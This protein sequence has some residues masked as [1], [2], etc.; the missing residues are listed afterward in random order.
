MQTRYGSIPAEVQLAWKSCLGGVGSAGLVP[1][2]NYNMDTP[3]TQYGSLPVAVQL[4]WRSCLGWFG[5]RGLVPMGNYNTYDITKMHATQT[6]YGSIP[7]EVW[8]VWRSCL[9]GFGLVGLVATENGYHTHLVWKHT[10]GSVACAEELPQGVRLSRWNSLR[11]VFPPGNGYCTDPLQLAWK[12]CVGGFGLAGLLPMGNYNTYDITKMHAAQTRY[13]SIPV[14]VWLVW[15]S[16]LGG[17]GL[18]GLVATVGE[19]HSEIYFPPKMDTTQTRYGSIPAEVRLV[20][21]SCLRG[22]GSA[23]LVSMGTYNVYLVS[24]TH[25]EMYFPRKM[26][27]AQIRCGLHGRAAS[28]GLAW[29][30]MHA[31]QTQYGSILVAV[32]LVWKCCLGWFGLAG[33]VAMGNHN[34]YLKMD[35]AQTW[36]GLHGRAASG[37]SAW[38]A[39]WL[40]TWYGSILAA[41][42]LV[43]KCC[44]GWFGSAGLVAMGNHNVYLTWCGLHGRAAS[45][46]SAWQAEWLQTWYGS[47]LA[48]VRLV[49]KR[50]LGWFSSA[51]LVAMGNHNVY[52]TWCSLHGRAASEGSAQ[53]ENGYRTDL[54]RLVQK[55]CLGWFSSAGLVPIGN[56]NMYDTTVSS[57]LLTKGL[58]ICCDAMY[59]MSP[60]PFHVTRSKPHGPFHVT[61]GKLHRPF[62]VTCG[63]L[64]GPFH[65]T[66]GKQH[67]P[68]HVTRGKPHRPFHVTCSKLYGPSHVIVACHKGPSM[69]LLMSCGHTWP[70]G[71]LMSLSLFDLAGLPQALHKPWHFGAQAGHEL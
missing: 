44:L 55:S 1:I 4:V 11:N 31:T 24:G 17:F 23:G 3:L 47:I 16:C 66:C 14:E 68:F 34:V 71:L 45:G 52:L 27:T 25:S 56:Y 41:V 35:T 10:C 2:G 8:L 5:F 51:G 61:H 13:G 32:R 53:Q 40:Q 33:L 69:G 9:G 38:Q 6:R 15:R 29:Q 50:C 21:K 64:H 18:A 49:R 59:G 48:A 54:V 12:S 26:D 43:W 36:C 65:V 63:K 58:S 22:F 19:T 28:G 20:W 7:V 62:H 30:K 67:G 60:G 70:S 46:G 42:Q 37:G 39:E 57:I